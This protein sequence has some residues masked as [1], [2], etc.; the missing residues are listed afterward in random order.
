MGVI[1]RVIYANKSRLRLLCLHLVFALCLIYEL[2]LTMHGK[3]YVHRKNQEVLMPQH[4]SIF[5]RSVVMATSQ[6]LRTG[7]VQSEIKKSG[8]TYL[9]DI[10]PFKNASPTHRDLPPIIRF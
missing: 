6:F 9:N 8:R 7:S 5:Q 1:K 3:E 10:L 4:L 2:R